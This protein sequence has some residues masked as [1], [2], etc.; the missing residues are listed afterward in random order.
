MSEIDH[1]SEDANLPITVSVS[2]KVIV[3]KEKDYEKWIKGVT[4]AAAKYVGH[5]GSSVLR[6]SNAT[7]GEYVLIYRFD[8]YLHA[9]T[10]ENSKE[11]KDWVNQLPPLVVG[12]A[13]RKRVTGLEF[14]FD[15]PSVEVTKTPSKIKMSLVLFVVVYTLVLTLATLLGPIIKDFPFW[16]KLLV[17]IPT[18]VLLMTYIVMPKVTGYLKNWLYKPFG[19]AS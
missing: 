1:I 19:S 18:Q 16:M 5:M 8:N 3:G 4:Q 13:K 12:E 2:R 17:I 10:W 9:Q 15:L 14:W 6:P 7:K 11:R